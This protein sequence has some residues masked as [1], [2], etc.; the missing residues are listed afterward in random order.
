MIRQATYGHGALPER[1]WDKVI[2]EPNSGCWLWDANQTRGGYGLFRM[3]ELMRYAHVLAF[4]AA[5]GPRP[6]GMDLD[7]LCR[8]RCC[9]NPDHLEPVTRREN[10]LR[11]LTGHAAGARNRAKTHCPKGHPYSDGYVRKNGSRQC[12]DCTVE[13]TRQRRRRLRQAN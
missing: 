2:P 10:C 1:F 8:V 12:K 4:E 3:G 9:V 13:Y 6:D 7:H 5:R 11:G